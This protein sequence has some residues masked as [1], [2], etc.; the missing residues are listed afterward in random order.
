MISA[1]FNSR[2][3]TLIIMFLSVLFSGCSNEDEK[4]YEITYLGGPNLKGL[5]NSLIGTPRAVQVRDESDIPAEG[6]EVVFSVIAGGG[7]IDNSIVRTDADG[8]AIVNWTLGSSGAQTLKAEAKTSNGKTIGEPVLF[9][10]GIIIEGSFTDTRDGEVYKTITIGSQ[11]WFA[12]N[13][14]YAAI[15]SFASGFN[16]DYDVDFGRYYNWYIAQTA[17]PDGWHHPSNDEWTALEVNLGIRADDGDMDIISHYPKHMKSVSMWQ[18][19]TEP[20]SAG[21]NAL[22]FNAFPAGYVSTVFGDAVD[23]GLSA[24]FWSS[25]IDLSDTT[26]A[27]QRRYFYDTYGIADGPYYNKLG[28][29][30]SVRCVL[31]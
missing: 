6:V 14:R 10:S 3:F 28:Y 18:S 23:S 12:Q 26:E 30:S 20:N 29:S 1:F 19:S 2:T 17:C 11:T 24:G 8:I 9:E 5:A 25:D 21:T 27:W 13:L 22:G 15:G 31:D 16:T 4:Y 7:S